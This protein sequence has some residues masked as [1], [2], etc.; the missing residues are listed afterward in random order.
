MSNTRVSLV[1][2]LEQDQQQLEPAL[3]A[4]FLKGNAGAAVTS[5]KDK[6]LQQPAVETPISKPKSPRRGKPAAAMTP[7]LVPVNVRVRPE[8]AQALQSASLD[9]Q[10]RGVEPY[11]KREIVEQALEPWL[12]SEG[13]LP[14]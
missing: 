1:D 4:A 9:R 2:R 13:Y 10:M 12:R 14:R 5:A 6:P 3:E 8:V 7:A 11:S